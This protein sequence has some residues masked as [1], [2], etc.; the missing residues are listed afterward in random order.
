MDPCTKMKYWNHFRQ[1]TKFSHSCSITTMPVMMVWH[2]LLSKQEAKFSINEG[3]IKLGNVLLTSQGLS[4]LQKGKASPNIQRKVSLVKCSYYLLCS[5]HI[6][7]SSENWLLN[8]SMNRQLIVAGIHVHEC[9]SV[10]WVFV[11]ILDVV[12]HFLFLLS[13]VG[14]EAPVA[15]YNNRHLLMIQFV[16]KFRITR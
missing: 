3:I 2:N 7:E 10:H 12:S 11:W 13:L 9:Y 15:Y 14:M 5:D 1:Q 4:E 8:I 16:Q 6:V